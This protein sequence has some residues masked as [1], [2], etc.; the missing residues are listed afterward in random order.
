[1]GPPRRSA[2]PAFTG[3]ARERSGDITDISRELRYAN[4]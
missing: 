2:R 1:M 3:V 4:S